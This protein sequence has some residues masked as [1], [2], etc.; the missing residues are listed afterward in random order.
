MTQIFA[1]KDLP[2]DSKQLCCYI[3]QTKTIAIARIRDIP[4]RDCERVVFPQER[5]LFEAPNNSNLEIYQH[6]PTGIITDTIPCSQLKLT[7]N[8]IADSD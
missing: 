5:F 8:I 6:T 7:E 4:G 3:N 1:P 2:P